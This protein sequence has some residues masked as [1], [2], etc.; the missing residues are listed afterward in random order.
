MELKDTLRQL[1]SELAMADD[2]AIKSDL[3]YAIHFVGKVIKKYQEKDK[4]A[5]RKLAKE[6]KEK[7]LARKEALAFIEKQRRKIKG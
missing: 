5:E 6:E 4:R 7:A 3:R 2:N 1:K